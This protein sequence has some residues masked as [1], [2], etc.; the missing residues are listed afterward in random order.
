MVQ[1]TVRTFVHPVRHAVEDGAYL[2]GT[3]DAVHGGQRGAGCVVHVVVE[4]EHNGVRVGGP[5][6]EGSCLFE[7]EN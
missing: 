7:S 2:A 6:G 3:G 4:H 5:W 1:E